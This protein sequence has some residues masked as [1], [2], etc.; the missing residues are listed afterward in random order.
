MFSPFPGSGGFALPGPIGL[1]G[2]AVLAEFDT[3]TEDDEPNFW[4]RE[5]KLLVI[6]FAKR[7][8][9]Q[10]FPRVDRLAVA[11]GL[12]ARIDFPGL[13]HQQVTSLCGPASL[14]FDLA[15]HDPVAYAQFGIDLYELGIA[16]IRKLE[17]KPGS[18]LKNYAIPPESNVDAADWVTMAS[19]RDSENWFFDYDEVDDEVGGIT[20]PHELANWFESVGY[21]D[22]RNETNLFFRKDESN[23]RDANRL[24]ANGYRVCLFISANMLQA[25]KQNNGSVT[26]DHWVVEM[27]P[28][29]M[30]P[31][32][33]K[34]EV[35]SWGRGRRQVP[36]LGGLLLT[37]SFFKNYY[38]YVAAHY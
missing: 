27:A 2:A 32:G 31:G 15:I 16:H 37:D 29:Q 9:P 8:T 30:L 35:F 3:V 22:I 6:A 26:P 28:I 21:T 20:L 17:I 23:A 38:G 13:I 10:A 7:S 33:V 5:A 1:D 34:T 18:D 25:A 14:L 4:R 11:R 12:M 36:E 24:L 19:I